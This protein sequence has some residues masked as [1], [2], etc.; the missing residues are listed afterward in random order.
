[1][2]AQEKEKKERKGKKSEEFTMWNGEVRVRGLRHAQRVVATSLFDVW[3]P[4]QQ[5][6]RR[7]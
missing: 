1:M 6:L 3:K 7:T 2:P 5:A 4:S